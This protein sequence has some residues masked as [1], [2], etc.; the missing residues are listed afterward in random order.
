[1]TAGTFRV[2]PG[3]FSVIG[4]RFSVIGDRFGVI[5]ENL[6][7]IGVTLHVIANSRQ[8]PFRRTIFVRLCREKIL[9]CAQDDREGGP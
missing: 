1:M 3:S 9:P 8:G 6:Q 2:I 4:G 7:S 5:G